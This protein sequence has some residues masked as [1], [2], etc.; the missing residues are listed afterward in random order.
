MIVYTEA[1]MSE[2]A[3]A[4]GAGWRIA[5]S[6]PA[7]VAEKF[8]DTDHLV[9]QLL[10]N[11]GLIDET[12]TPKQLER[13]L[14]PDFDA[15]LHD[16]LLMPGMTEALD[17]I[18]KAIAAGEHITIY[19]DYDADGVPGAAVLLETLKPLTEHLD[20]YI[21]AREDE[22]YGL[23]EGPIQ[24]LKER[25]TQLI[26]T[27]DCGIKDSAAVELAES[28]GMEVIVSDHHE[29]PETPPS[30]IVVHAR[31]K[32]SKYPYGY[33]CGAG[34]AYKIACAVV[35]RHPEKYGIGF[36]KWL[37]DL[38]GLATVADMVPLVDE[39][40]VLAYYGL[41]VLRKSRRLGLRELLRLSK[42]EQREMNSSAI[43]FVLG[44]RLNAPGRLGSA[45]ESLELL[46]ADDPTDAY[47]LA[48]H[49]LRQNTARQ[50][51]TN[52]AFEEASRQIDAL[53]ELP[54]VIVVKG[55]WHKG[56]LGIVA[57]KLL[58]RYGRPVFVMA[59]ESAPVGREG[60][61]LRGSAR[62]VD[63]FSLPE[64][65]NSCS[66]LLLRGGGHKLAAGFALLPEHEAAFRARL[67]EL[68]S[69]LDPESFAEE[70][71]AD[72]ELT[73]NQ[74]TLEQWAEIERL[75]PYGFGNARPVFVSR[76][77]EVV[78]A[79]R[80]GKTADHLKLTLRQNGAIQQAILFSH[81]DLPVPAL[82]SRVNICYEVE[83]SRWPTDPIRGRLR[84]QL[85]V[86]AM[87]A[88]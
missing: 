51:V 44:P 46:L 32:G 75:E 88:A 71:E 67:A 20:Y 9:L 79:Q 50:K 38:V 80:V 48:E 74:V 37:L 84:Q 81:G 59:E 8:T 40:R 26:I 16:P 70:L 15:G 5:K 11:R 85:C 7:E 30:C 76:G 13:V 53:P 28:L 64:A 31:L 52:T 43:S 23:T 6:I 49:L 41:I 54:K 86:R 63:N 24:K 78:R 72:A 77:V 61:E 25:G 60:T 10:W 14:K 36:T 19:G 58:E 68:A 35:D 3:A 56:V 69:G 39:N 47:R 12:T 1:I 29:V 87:E 22:G 82:R 42:V 21:P 17:R 62:S 65:L 34:V 45:A 4:T 18:D 66:D 55:D 2:S 57:G 83:V 33:L 27:V 73:L